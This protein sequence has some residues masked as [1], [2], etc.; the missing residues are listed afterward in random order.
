[1]NGL[2]GGVS[3]EILR[4]VLQMSGGYLIELMEEWDWLLRALSFGGRI[5]NYLMCNG[6]P[7]KILEN[8]GDVA[9]GAGADDN[10]GN[11]AM[12]VVEFIEDSGW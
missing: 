6:E 7:V 9:L 5:S 3:M 12:D 2:G 1:M 10:K 8:G 11:R 4:D